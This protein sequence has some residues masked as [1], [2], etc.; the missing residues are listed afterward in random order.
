M[1]CSQNLSQNETANRKLSSHLFLVDQH[2]VTSSQCH[3]QKRNAFQFHSLGHSKSKH[4]CNELC[5][6]LPKCQLAIYTHSSRR[7]YGLACSNAQLC[8]FINGQLKQFAGHRV[9]K[10]SISEDDTD[11]V[12]GS[13]SHSNC[14]PAKE[15]I[16]A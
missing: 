12:E 16:S 14:T 11:N 9:D 1:I 10:R 4:K 2:R 13:Y 3:Q 15:N 8:N 5:C 7:C 6:R